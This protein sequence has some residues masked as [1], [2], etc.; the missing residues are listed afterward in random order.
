[1][2]NAH[3]ENVKKK[4]TKLNFIEKLPKEDKRIP[5]KLS[6]DGFDYVINLYIND[7]PDMDKFALTCKNYFP[8]VFGNWELVKE[9]NLEEHVKLALTRGVKHIYLRVIDELYTEQRARYSH[10]DFVNDLSTQIYGPFI[11]NYTIKEIKNKIPI[12]EIRAFLKEAPEVQKF[13]QQRIEE[14]DDEIKLI[15]ACLKWNKR[16]IYSSI[17][18]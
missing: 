5:Y 8:L 14:L 2:S 18:H 4:L 16:N 10:N 13:V 1:M 12:N 9:Y 11:F 3:W 15:T 17:F 7:I 6:E